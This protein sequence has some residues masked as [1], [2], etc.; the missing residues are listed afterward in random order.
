M[1][2]NIWLLF[3]SLIALFNIIVSYSF[4]KKNKKS[5]YLF[6]LVF[7]IYFICLLLFSSFLLNP[8]LFFLYFTS[9]CSII[10]YF[11]LKI[12]KYN[13]LKFFIAILYSIIIIYN[14]SK[15]LKYFHVSEYWIGSNLIT[16]YLLSLSVIFS[17]IF[18]I[19]FF[20]Y[21][22]IKMFFK[23]EKNKNKLIIN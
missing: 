1:S 3:L 15:L 19:V 7:N 16:F 9:L 18:Y 17:F 21:K 14:L 13:I 10:L 4:I 22:L 23:L 20:G 12:I 6:F 5:F 2:K 11:L 8:I